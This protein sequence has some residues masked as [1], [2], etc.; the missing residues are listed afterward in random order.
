[1]KVNISVT[2]SIEAAMHLEDVKNKSKY[3]DELILTDIM[4]DRE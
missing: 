3:I 4:S 1:M 2:V